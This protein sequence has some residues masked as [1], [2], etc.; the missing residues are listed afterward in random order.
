MYKLIAIEGLDGSG[1]ET[2]SIILRD[3]LAAAGR[4]VGMMS[5]PD[6]DSPGSAPV[7]MYLAGKLGSRPDD[8]NAYAASVLFAAD[9]LVSWKS[10]CEREFADCEF[11]IANRYTTANAYHQLSKLPRGEWDA[12]LDWLFELEFERMRLPRPD[13]VICLLNPP[14]RSLELIERRSAETGVKKDIHEA[15]ADYLRRCY[16]AAIYA[17]ERLGW[18]LI[19]CVDDGGALLS[20]EA[21]HGKITEALARDELFAPEERT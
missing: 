2:Q 8:V 11:I 15:D 10:R 20:R 19:S 3:A 7:K 17:G 21:M 14:E 1:K 18:T 4:R 6:Y 12:F 5:F 16:E 13:K 9:R